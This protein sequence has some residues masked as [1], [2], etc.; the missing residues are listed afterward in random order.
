MIFIYQYN[1]AEEYGQV[2]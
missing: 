2:H 1:I